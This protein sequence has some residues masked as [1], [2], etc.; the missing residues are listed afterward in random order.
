[1]VQGRAAP[2]P[3]CR[4]AKNQKDPVKDP[5][6][7]LNGK[8]PYPCA[9]VPG[10]TSRGTCRSAGRIDDMPVSR[11]SS[12]GFR[13][14]LRPED[15][16]LTI[17]PGEL[18][19]RFSKQNQDEDGADQEG[20]IQDG[21]GARGQEQGANDD[22]LY[23]HPVRIPRSFYM[24]ATEV[25]VGSFVSS[26]RRRSIKRRRKG[27]LAANTPGRRIPGARRTTSRWCSCHGTMP[28]RSASG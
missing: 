22:E 6:G 8:K 19:K 7:D 2:V 10:A 12:I 18:A 3:R 1:M 20:Y 15:R 14:V 23:R 24:A 16:P 4:T 21:L 17:Q 5:K 27:E 28:W 25:T 13:V 26:S 9:A 11:W